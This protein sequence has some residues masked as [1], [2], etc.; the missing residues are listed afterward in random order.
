MKNRKI[1]ILLIVLLSA[2]ITFAQGGS[3]FNFA[4]LG[5]ANL[6]NLNGKDLSGNKLDND[7]LVGFHAGVNAQIRIAP[8]FYFQPGLMFATKGAS[9]S[10]TVLGVTGS[11]TTTLNYL[12]LP[13]NV[14]YKASVGSGSIML[15]F[16]P[17]LAYGLGGKSKLKVG[18]ATTNFDVKFQNT[19][20]AKD[21]L[22]N[23]GTSYYRPFDA[24]ANIFFGYETAMGIFLQLETQ[25]GLLDINSDYKGVNMDKANTKNTGFGLSLG[26]RF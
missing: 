25:L 15:G 10:A 17:Y 1:S 12:E 13:L 9:Y 14:V 4:V 18:G 21:I 7:M 5:G 11:S 23:P 19:V 16:G 20:D 8:E 22:A 24:G 6:Q 26:Y 2:T 3:G